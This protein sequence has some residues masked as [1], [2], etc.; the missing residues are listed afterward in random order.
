MASKPAFAP[1]LV[2][3]EGKDKGKVISLNEGTAIIGR[4]KGDVLVQ[5]PRVSRS[6]VAIHYDE[7]SGKL[8]FT[9]LKSLNGTQLNGETREAGEIA[10]GDRLQLGNTLF[11]CQIVSPEIER[12]LSP[13]PSLNEGS[14]SQEPHSKINPVEV[15]RP[16]PE[17]IS[18]QDRERTRAGRLM[19]LKKWYLRVPRRARVYGLTAGVGVVLFYAVFGGS[20]TNGLERELSSIKTLVQEGKVTEALTKAETVIK[21]HPDNVQARILMGEMYRAQGKVELAIVSFRKALDLDPTQVALHP[22]LARLYLLNGA[23]ADAQVQNA[24]IDRVIQE[25]PH[26]KEFF[27]EVANLYLDFRELNI[28]PKKMAIIGQALQHKFAPGEAIGMKLE[29]VGLIG[30]D[31]PEEALG[32]LEKARKISPGDASIYQ[33]MV[34]AKAKLNDLPGASVLVQEWIKNFPK[35]TQPLLIMAHWKFEGKDYPAALDYANRL[36][37][38]AKAQGGDPFLADALNLVGKIFEGQNQPTEA[39]M[40]YRQSCDLGFQG[41]CESPLIANQ[42]NPSET[43]P[44]A[45]AQVPSPTAPQAGTTSSAAPV[46]NPST[47]R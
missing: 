35:S 31:S 24:E 36:I 37:Q 22:K 12:S 26:S 43:R 47:N 10:D 15:S 9:D 34:F 42:G 46:G 19:P 18:S 21:S 38:V 45:S 1:R 30:L 4:S 11:D 20:S 13:L 33:S 28:A 40:A 25:G 32:L 2:I 39:T 27:V 6:H 7:R 23:L 29:A 3:I 5:D 17:Q 44:E 16:G 14:Y 8:T 41:S